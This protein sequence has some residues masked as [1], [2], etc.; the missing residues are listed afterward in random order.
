M[1]NPTVDEAMPDFWPPRPGRFWDAAL[2][3]VRGWFLRRVYRISEVEVRGLDAALAKIGPRDGLLVAPNHS[4]DSDPHV[5]MEVAARSRRRFHFMAAWQIFRMHGGVDGWALQRMGAFSVDREGCDRRAVRQAVE[6]LSGGKTLVVFPEGEVYHLNDRLTPLLDGVAFMAFSAQ[7]DLAKSNGPGGAAAAP[8]VWIVPTAI[9]YRYVEDIAPALDAAVTRME[10]RLRVAPRPGGP[11]GERVLHLGDVLLTI[12]EKEKLGRAGEGDLHARIA[13]LVESI[14]ARQEDLHLK[15]PRRG[16][17]VALRVK[18]LRRHLLDVRADAEAPAEA[19][20]AARR[21]L[22]DVQLA[23][24]LYSYPGDYVAE[25][26]SVER[27]AE[28]IE[29]FEEDL[30]GSSLPKG[31]RRALVVFGDPIDVSAA[32]HGARARAASG[33]ITERLEAEIARLMREN[34]A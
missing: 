7:R 26:P 31:R 30:D 29:K 22:D 3:P 13:A 23:M 15:A 19:R 17:S 5:M 12:Q 21:G 2:A 8:R 20:D 10:T 1:W 16:D 34:A 4:H 24:T 28:T 32:S 25:R 14:L 6:I 9:R 11:L 18:A 27:I 33:E